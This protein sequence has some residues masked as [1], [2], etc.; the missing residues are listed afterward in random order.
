MPPF[1]LTNQNGERISLDTFRGQPFCSRSFSRAVR[2]RISA[3]DVEQFR[4]LQTAIKTGSGSLAKTQ[5][6]SVTLDPDYDTPKVLNDYAAFHHA[7]PEIWT[8]VTGDEKEIDSLTRAFSV[9]RQTEGG[10]IS[11][12]LATAL[13]NRDGTIE[14]IWRG[15]AWTPAEVT[16][17]IQA[18]GK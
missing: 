8:F 11:H 16:Q 10:T 5:L 12:G 7:D 13:I 14:R 17:A 15:N 4:G 3:R 6:L 18:E 2:C 9:Y 1:S